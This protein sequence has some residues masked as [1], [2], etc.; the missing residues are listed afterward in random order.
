M[1]YVDLRGFDTQRDAMTAIVQIMSD[2]REGF[3]T[4]K[5]TLS[6]LNAVAEEW[7]T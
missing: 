6:L 5:E 7:A 4:H 1:A 3:T 2:W